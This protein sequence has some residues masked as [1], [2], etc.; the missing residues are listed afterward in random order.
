MIP[1]TARRRH[2]SSS[3]S[4]SSSISA[5][6]NPDNASAMAI[7][8]ISISDRYLWLS[9]GTHPPPSVPSIHPLTHHTTRP[10]HCRPKHPRL[11][12]SPQPPHPDNNNHAPHA[13]QHNLGPNPDRPGKRHQNFRPPNPR[14]LP[15][16]R[17][18]CLG[19]HHP[20]RPLLRLAFRAQAA[21]SRPRVP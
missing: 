4:S 2:P 12:L 17:H 21:A 13:P 9:L 6:I 16:H 11:D 5:N 14:H 19:N 15:Q 3:P 20:V 10:P 18:P 1:V 7:S 8:S